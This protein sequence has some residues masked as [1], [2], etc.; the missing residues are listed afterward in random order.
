MGELP[1]FRAVV[2]I[3]EKRWR[4]V[5]AAWSKRE[6]KLSLQMTTMPIP[7]NGKVNVLLVPNNGKETA[8]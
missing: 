8:E 3:G 1:D 5:G 4:E 2:N 7:K 6:G